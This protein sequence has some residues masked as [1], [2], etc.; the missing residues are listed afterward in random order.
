MKEKKEI[1]NNQC[2]VKGCGC[3]IK[4]IYLGMIVIFIVMFIATII[5]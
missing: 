2:E 1:N 4:Y 5:K 3:N